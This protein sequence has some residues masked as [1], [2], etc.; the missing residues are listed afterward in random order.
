M[1]L[2]AIEE[3]RRRLV[4]IVLLIYIALGYIGG[5]EFAARKRFIRLSRNIEGVRNTDFR[6]LSLRY[7]VAEVDGL[8]RGEVGRD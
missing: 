8:F 1:G 3:I 7:R 5:R 6:L 2:I 4:Y